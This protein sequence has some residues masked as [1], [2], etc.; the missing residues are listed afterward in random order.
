MQKTVLLHKHFKIQLNRS[1]I[2]ITLKSRKMVNH[3]WLVVTK[4]LIDFFYVKTWEVGGAITACNDSVVNF[5]G[6]KVSLGFI[7]FILPSKYLYFT[8]KHFLFCIDLFL[9][10]G[11]CLKFLQI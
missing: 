2:D 3:H 9:Q 7:Y 8:K 10:L 11:Q 4:L 1:M 6:R 5:S